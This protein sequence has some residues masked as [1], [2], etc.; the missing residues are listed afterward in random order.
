[1]RKVSMVNPE[2]GT[3]IELNWHANREQDAEVE[4]IQGGKFG[5]YLSAEKAD[6][7]IA[8]AKAKGWPCSESN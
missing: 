8:N 6:K 7:G 1:M 2:T 3:T 5:G 4:L